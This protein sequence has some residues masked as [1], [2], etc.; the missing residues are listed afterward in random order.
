MEQPD[1]G[2]A[3]SG[4]TIT[5]VVSTSLD[6]S[7]KVLGTAKVNGKKV[8]LTGGSKSVKPGVLGKFKVKVPAALKAALAALPSGKSIKI[9]LTASA[10]NLVGPETVDKTSVKLP[11]TKR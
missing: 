3:P 8:K 7:V 6:A 10:V 1:G 11:G 4:K 2:A 9:Q 5:V